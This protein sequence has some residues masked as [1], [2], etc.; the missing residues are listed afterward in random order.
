M[1]Y[2][3]SLYISLSF[4]TC[5]TASIFTRFFHLFVC[6]T[7]KVFQFCAY[8]PIF[9]QDCCDFYCTVLHHMMSGRNARVDIYMR[10]VFSPPSILGLLDR[11]CK[12]ELQRSGY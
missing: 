3:L 2:L 7:D 10:D 11:P 1:P 12:L 4:N 5:K 6:V 8:K 9:P